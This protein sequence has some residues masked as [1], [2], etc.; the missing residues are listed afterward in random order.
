MLGKRS[1]DLIIRLRVVGNS[2]ELVNLDEKLQ[3]LGE[4]KTARVPQ[5]SLKALKQRRPFLTQEIARSL[6][7]TDILGSLRISRRKMRVD[8]SDPGALNWK[9]QKKL[10]NRAGHNII[11]DDFSKMIL[12][13]DDRLRLAISSSNNY[14]KRLLEDRRKTEV[15]LQEVASSYGRLSSSALARSTRSR[16]CTRSSRATTF[17]S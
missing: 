4:D 11:K 1:E 14:N 16:T 10:T 12:T 8:P 9:N 5:E 7:K 15:L 2:V 17:R 3:D 6:K 13:D